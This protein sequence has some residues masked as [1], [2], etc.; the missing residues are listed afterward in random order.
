MTNLLIFFSSKGK[1]P[2]PIQHVINLGSNRNR[3]AILDDNK[4]EEIERKVALTIEQIPQSS[5]DI[6]EEADTLKDLSIL[7]GAVSD[8]NNISSAARIK[9][10]NDKGES[11]NKDL[12]DKLNARANE[13][14]RSGKK[15]KDKVNLN[16]F[17]LYT[18]F[19]IMR[20]VNETKVS[21]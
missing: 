2:R 3:D 6:Q 16:Q 20:H 18:T 7:A 5:S 4:W 8:N 12:Y 10:T 21:N 11:L 19:L 14:L 1:L 15:L 17:V 9:V 13:R